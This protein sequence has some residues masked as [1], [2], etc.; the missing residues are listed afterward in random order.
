MYPTYWLPS[1]EFLFKLLAFI[2]ETVLKHFRLHWE[3]HRV[4]QHWR[5]LNPCGWGSAPTQLRHQRR[6]YRYRRKLHLRM[7]ARIHW[8]RSYL[9]RLVL[10]IQECLTVGCVPPALYRT[11]GVSLDRDTKSPLDREPPRTGTPLD[12]EPL[13]RDRLVREPLERD[14]LDRDLWTET[15]WKEYGIRQPGRKWH[16]IKTSCGQIDACE[17][18]TLIQTSFAGGKMMLIVVVNFSEIHVKHI[19]YQH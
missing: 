1:V 14:P 4:R 19:F 6:L 17:N 16:H 13:D 3:W 8:W 10:V 5:V 9:W 15:P 18:I 7:P 11:R 2:R 12:R